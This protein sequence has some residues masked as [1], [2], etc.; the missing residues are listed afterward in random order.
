MRDEDQPPILGSWPRMYA[1][2][3]G[4]LL[5]LIAV[6]YGFAQRFAP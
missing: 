6:F 5:F 1:A 2:V 3:I 4:W